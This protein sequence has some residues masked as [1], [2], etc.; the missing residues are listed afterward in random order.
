MADLVT[1]S[2]LK[3]AFTEFPEMAALVGTMTTNLHSITTYNK[4][5]VGSDSIGQQYQSTVDTPTKNLLDL[6]GQIQDLMTMTG[7]NG[8]DAAD[9]YDAANDDATTVANGG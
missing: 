7:N 4:E 2:Q 9:N 5:A 3:S 8:S 6:M 1:L